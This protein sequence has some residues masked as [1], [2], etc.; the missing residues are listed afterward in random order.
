MTKANILIAFKL[1]VNERADLVHLGLLNIPVATPAP[2]VSPKYTID[3]S[4]PN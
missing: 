4:N 3:P 1:R 2:N